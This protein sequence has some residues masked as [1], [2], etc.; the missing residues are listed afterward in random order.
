MFDNSSLSNIYNETFF[1][2][3][4]LIYYWT[5]ASGIEVKRDISDVYT[6]NQSIVI[7]VDHFAYSNAVDDGALIFC[8]MLKVKK[9]DIASCNKVEMSAVWHYEN[10][11]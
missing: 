5:W 4:A 2:T 6:H 8:C 9:Q 10:V 7:Q 1:E 11:I 3:Y